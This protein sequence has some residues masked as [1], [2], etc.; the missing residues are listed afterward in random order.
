MLLSY[1]ARSH[2]SSAWLISSAQLSSAQQRTAA[3]VQQSAA[4]CGA[5]LCRAVCF[6]VLT[7]SYMPVSFEV[8]LHQVCTYYVVEL[9]TM[10]P[11]LRSARLHIYLSSA[12]QRSAVRCGAVPCPAFC[13]AVSCGAVLSF[14]HTAV[15]PG[16]IQ[17]PGTG[18]YVLCTRLFAVFS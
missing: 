1:H 13:G 12:A 17:V 14:E 5:M 4:P 2:L 11:Q 3:L 10:H 8:S 6:A 15:V 9:Q 7:R 16:M 18:M